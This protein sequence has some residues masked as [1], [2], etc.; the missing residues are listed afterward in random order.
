[1]I[2]RLRGAAFA[3]ACSAALSA[4]VIVLDTFNA[5][6][7]TG[8]VRAGTSWSNNV[9]FTAGAIAVGGSALDDNG[10]GATGLTLDATG[11]TY[12]TLSAQQLPGNAVGSIFV[13]FEDRYLHTRIIGFNASAFS[14]TTFIT[15]QTP[16]GAWGSEFDAANI[17]SWSIGGG[18]LG[19][20]SLRMS[21]EHLALTASAIPEPAATAGVLAIVTAATGFYRRRYF[22]SAS[23]ARR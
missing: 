2:A 22:R 9:T 20:Q 8:E 11:M 10:W 16:I 1:M 13:Q 19:T 4:Q 6:T 23:S 15:A 17:V 12:L 14:T 7:A 3:L 21:F 18:G 5:G